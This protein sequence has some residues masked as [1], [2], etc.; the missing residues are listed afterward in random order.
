MFLF[1][2]IGGINFIPFIFQKMHFYV[3]VS[4]LH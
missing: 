3:F 2:L 1:L 4:D